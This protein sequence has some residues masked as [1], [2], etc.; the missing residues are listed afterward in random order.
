MVGVEQRE[1]ELDRKARRK[2][3]QAY[4]E[5]REWYRGRLDRE[6]KIKMNIGC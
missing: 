4:A 2:D 3:R 5:R 1:G 6:E